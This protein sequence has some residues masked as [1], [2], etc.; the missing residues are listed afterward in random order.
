M[1]L[2]DHEMVLLMPNGA[3]RKMGGLKVLSGRVTE[4]LDAY[5]TQV[6]GHTALLYQPSTPPMLDLDELVNK[7]EG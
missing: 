7:M 5:V 2:W 3:G 1:Y 4:I 6:I